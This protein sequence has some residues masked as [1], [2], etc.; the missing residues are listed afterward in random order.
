[1]SKKTR[2]VIDLE[3]KDPK[4]EKDSF[5]LECKI[6]LIG[7]GKDLVFSLVNAMD[8]NPEIKE[9]VMEASKQTLLKEIM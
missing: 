3:L 5:E 4:T 7:T 8:K 9:I 6:K 1:M 2:L